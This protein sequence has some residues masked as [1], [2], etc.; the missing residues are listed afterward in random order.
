MRSVAARRNA[1][2]MPAALCG[3]TP[4]DTY[5]CPA[6]CAEARALLVP[7]RTRRRGQAEFQMRRCMYQDN[8]TGYTQ[9][10]EPTNETPAVA[11][12]GSGTWQQ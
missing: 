9:K 1:L 5:K 3:Y 2:E 10:Q 4:T 12:L 6:K 7:G 8:L 11:P